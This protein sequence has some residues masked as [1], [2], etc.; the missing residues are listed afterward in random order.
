MNFIRPFVLALIVMSLSSLGF[1]DAGTRKL[2]RT[3]A[4][5]NATNVREL[6]TIRPGTTCYYA[7][8]QTGATDAHGANSA[9][10]FV[11]P[12]GADLCIDTNVA[13]AD[14]NDLFVEIYRVV[15]APTTNGSFLPLASESKLDKDTRDCFH[16]IAGSYWLKVTGGGAGGSQVAVVSITGSND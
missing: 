12:T 16:A 14:D 8:S 11:P 10:F 13:G 15:S 7:F 5:T 6:C 9:E 4:L 1:A 3:A 2:H